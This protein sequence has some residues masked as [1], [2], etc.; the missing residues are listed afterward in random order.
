M[1]LQAWLLQLPVRG[2]RNPPDLQLDQDPDRSPERRRPLQ[3]VSVSFSIPE[4]RRRIFK[5]LF[6]GHYL[7]QERISYPH[8]DFRPYQDLRKPCNITSSMFKYHIKVVLP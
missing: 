6:K 2:L 8:E 5:K 3:N 1:G 4:I 7:E